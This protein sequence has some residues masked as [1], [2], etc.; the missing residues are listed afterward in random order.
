LESIFGNNESVTTE[1]F[2]SSLQG[3]IPD[4]TLNFICEMIST[5][6]GSGG[7]VMR[8]ADVQDFITHEVTTED[9]NKPLL[10][11]HE[12]DDTK[13]ADRD[14]TYRMSSMGTQ[15]VLRDL[16]TVGT[17]TVGFVLNTVKFITKLPAKAVGVDPKY[18]QGVVD[19]GKGMILELGNVVGGTLKVVSKTFLNGYDIARG[20][21][22]FDTMQI[23]FT[24]REV[25]NKFSNGITL[26]DLIKSLREQNT[27][28]RCVGPIRVVGYQGQMYTLD[29]RQLYCLQRAGI[30]Y[31]VVRLVQLRDVEDEWHEK[32]TTTNGGTSVEIIST[33]GALQPSSWTVTR[34]TINCST[35]FP[36]IR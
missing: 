35:F 8:K 31:A 10:R 17:S 22:L 32:F 13:I 36:D 18:T 3:Q 21:H 4:E 11:D 16:K 33:P 28:S 34:Q 14:L 29:N 9:K 24:R 12:G 25:S 19:D 2:R 30:E 15:F 26:D 23:R 6:D 1:E 5:Q 7:S 27:T 20:N